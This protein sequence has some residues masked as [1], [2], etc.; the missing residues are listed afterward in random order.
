MIRRGL[1]RAPSTRCSK[2]TARIWRRALRSYAAG[3]ALTFTPRRCVSLDH[4]LDRGHSRRRSPSIPLSRSVRIP[5]DRV[6]RSTERRATHSFMHQLTQIVVHLHDLV[7]ALSGPCTR[8][9]C[10]RSGRDRR[11]ADPHV[12]G[13]SSASSMQLLLAGA[14]RLLDLVGSRRR[15]SRWATTPS[16]VAVSRN[17]SSPRSTNR[18]IELGASL[19]CS[20]E[21][22]RWP[23]SE[24]CTA[25]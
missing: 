13:P 16:I 17:G 9:R 22:T 1:P 12:L 5:R 15:T 2:P 20:V 18:M 7:Q 3:P 21:S 23:V 19:V 11:T 8:R 10:S 25:I 14:V 4:F 6:V 24:A